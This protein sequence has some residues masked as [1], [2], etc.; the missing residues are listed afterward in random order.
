VTTRAAAAG[1]G[2]LTTSFKDTMRTNYDIGGKVKTATPD[3]TGLSSTMTYGSPT[4]YAAPSAVTTG[5]LGQ[6]RCV[7]A[8]DA[9]D[10]PGYE[11]Q[12]RAVNRYYSSVSGRFLTADPYVASGGRATHCITL[13]A[14]R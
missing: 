6:T 11:S 9:G 1:A 4:N 10:G 5:S 14:F 2:G 12:G 7:G 13:S 3:S 8:D